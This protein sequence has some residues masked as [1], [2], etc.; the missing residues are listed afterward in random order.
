[1]PTRVIVSSDEKL[2]QTVRMGAH[3]LTVDEP[4]EGGGGD[5]GPNPYELLLAALGACTSM[6][7]LIYARRK[8]WP[9]EAVEVRLAHQRIHA[10]DCADCEQREGYLDHV[11]KEI[12]VTGPLTAEQVT[13]LGEIAEMCPV[14]RTLHQTVHTTLVIRLSGDAGPTP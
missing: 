6:T 13:R 7:L 3:S 12:I 1:M 11:D 9:L 2:R 5:A 10:R 14:N 4:A 8:E